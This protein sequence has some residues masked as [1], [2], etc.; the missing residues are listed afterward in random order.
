MEPDNARSVVTTLAPEK[1]AYLVQAATGVRHLP[2]A[3]A[4][5]GVYQGGSL[6]LIAGTLREK[7]VYGIDTFTGM[8]NPSTFDEHVAG[9]RL[10]FL[11]QA[12]VGQL[13]MVGQFSNRVA[14]RALSRG[15]PLRETVSPHIR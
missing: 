5:V 12:E 13:R 11:Q 4:E 1:R 9:G 3:A 14:Q 7:R 10:H 6:V 8:P 15:S 2:G